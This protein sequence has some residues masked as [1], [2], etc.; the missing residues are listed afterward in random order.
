MPVLTASVSLIFCSFTTSF[1]ISVFLVCFS[2]FYFVFARFP[3]RSIARRPRQHHQWEGVSSGGG[4]VA[5]DEPRHGRRGRSR[6][7][8]PAG[9][10]RHLYFSSNFVCFCGKL[11]F[12]LACD[13]VYYSVFLCLFWRCAWLDFSNSRSWAYASRKTFGRTYSHR[14]LL[15][16]LI[17]LWKINFQHIF[18]RWPSGTIADGGRGARREEEEEG[19]RGWLRR[20]FEDECLS[21][22]M[23]VTTT[24]SFP[25]S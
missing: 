9:H 12:F 3:F 2:L 8:L 20:W 1:L 22:R 5:G 23:F 15:R 18:P 13:V 14:Y 21:K 17:F 19:G 11:A 4:G 6:N 10:N 7:S 25:K 16:D 24:R